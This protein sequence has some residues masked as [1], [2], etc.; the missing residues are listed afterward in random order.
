MILERHGFSCRSLGLQ[1]HL[2]AAGVVGIAGWGAALPRCRGF[3]QAS[4]A[5]GSTSVGV[6]PLRSRGG[7]ESV[8]TPAGR[9]ADLR[10]ARP[11]WSGVAFGSARPSNKPDIPDP[12]AAGI[13]RLAPRVASCLVGAAGP[14]DVGPG[15]PLRSAQIMKI[16]LQACL[17]IAGAFWCSAEGDYNHE[18]KGVGSAEYFHQTLHYEGHPEFYL[19][20]DYAVKV[21]S[22]GIAVLAAQGWEEVVVSCTVVDAIRGPKKVGERFEYRR[23]REGKAKET[24]KLLGGLRYVFFVEAPGGERFVD[25]QDP[26]SVKDYS[27]EFAR[28]V[29]IHRRPKAEQVVPPNRSATPNLKPESSL[30]GPED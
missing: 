29:A 11:P 23:Y 17:G 20:C 14:A 13:R 25:P 16:L 27:E 24:E 22:H 15:N 19:V 2:N 7:V 28:I 21:Q 12:S 26:A 18:G 9:K 8:P 5:G 4:E 6:D 1:D 3:S 10:A 30:R